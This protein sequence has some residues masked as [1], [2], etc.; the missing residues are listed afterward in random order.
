MA[1]PGW[2]EAG[3]PGRERWWDGTDWSPHEREIAR[4]A[5]PMGWYVQPGADQ[6][7][8]WTGSYWSGYILR[9]GVPAAEPF[10]V[11]PSGLGWY[12]GGVLLLLAA[13]LFPL[14]LLGFGF[15]GLSGAFIVLAVM[16][17][18][19][20]A[21]ASRRKKSPP[22]QTAAIDSA[23]VRPLPGQQD[24]PDAG[25]YRLTASAS[26]WWT[27]TTW[28]H[29][30]SERGIVRPS[31]F[32]PRSLRAAGIVTAILG[33]LG[34]VLLGIGGAVTASASSSP[35]IGL[36]VLGALFLLLAVAMLGIVLASRRL[37]LLPAHP[38]A[39]ET[40]VH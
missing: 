11:E 28:A 25:W 18:R 2:Y 8:W 9:R 26:R 13:G 14:S 10:A 34:A 21:T 16:F 31:H 3:T 22:P 23:A 35:P 24:A 40:R 12:L 30:V 29:Y 33:G 20:A 27:G 5:P 1:Q 19:G 36:F 38:P 39:P 4:T 32:G 17:M 6:E 15:A 7:R 37:S